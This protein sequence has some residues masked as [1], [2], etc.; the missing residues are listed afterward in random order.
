MSKYK[1]G[2]TVQFI[3]ENQL[4]TGEIQ[5]MNVYT[6]G[7]FNY[8]VS[9]ETDSGSIQLWKDEDDLVLTPPL[10][11]IP[12]FVADNIEGNKK[13]GCALCDSLHNIVEYLDYDSEIYKWLREDEIE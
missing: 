11:E 8:L 9:V 12:Q 6:T 2:D 5:A 7:S 10:P 13:E 4:F 3:E 1:I